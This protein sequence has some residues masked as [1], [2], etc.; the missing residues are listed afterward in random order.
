VHRERSWNLFAKSRAEP[1]I[2][3]VSVHPMAIANR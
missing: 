2:L 1:E 3:G